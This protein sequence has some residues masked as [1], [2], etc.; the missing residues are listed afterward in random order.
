MLW[1]VSNRCRDFAANSLNI[2]DCQ[3]EVLDGQLGVGIIVNAGSSVRIEGNVL[4][5]FLS[6]APQHGQ[7]GC[8]G[9]LH[10]ADR[11]IYER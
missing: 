11:T 6:V 1:I 2:L 9:N 10:F 8:S 3:V 4:G 7:E 5:G